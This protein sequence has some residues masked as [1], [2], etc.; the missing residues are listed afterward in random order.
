MPT[1]TVTVD[2]SYHY[3]VMNIL[4]FHFSTKKF[5]KY[6]KIKTF[7]NTTELNEHNVLCQSVT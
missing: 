3:A 4:F 6:S 1:I 2:S 5:L 7:H